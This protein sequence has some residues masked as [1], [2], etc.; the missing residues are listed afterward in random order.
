MPIDINIHNVALS[1]RYL[2]SEITSKRKVFIPFAPT[3]PS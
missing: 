1:M 2:V 3:S